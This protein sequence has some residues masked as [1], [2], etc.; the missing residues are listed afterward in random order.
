MVF[1]ADRDIRDGLS[2]GA[3][4]DLIGV[5]VRTLHHWDEIGLATPSRRSAAGYRQYTEE[6]LERLDRIVAYRETGLG[7]DAVRRVL[8]DRA[9]DA[10]A[11]LR[12]QRE[13]L[14]ERI[15]DLQRLDQRLERMTDAHERGIL[16]D[17]EE[18]AEIF[19]GDWDPQGPQQA[20]SLWGGTDQW[21]QFAERSAHRTPGQWRV[22]SG[23]MSALQ[24]ELGDAM[25][26]GVAPGSPEAD[27]LVERH[28]ELFSNFFTLTRE[29]QVCLGRMFESDQGFAAHYDS[30]RPGLASWF[31][32]IIDASARS[33][34]IDPDNA[35]WR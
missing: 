20:R 34:G 11:I 18:Q 25:A 21:A 10:A 22:L 30:V 9:T 14:A 8:D 33:H 4:A 32:R 6:D 12:R 5:T 7:L 2:V 24:Q 27:A 31:R 1:M 3:A 15:E 35:V 16:L 28:R 26:D 29:M 19:G 13:Q 17:D 23:E